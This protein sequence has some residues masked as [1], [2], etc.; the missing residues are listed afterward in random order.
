MTHRRLDGHDVY[1]LINDSPKPWQGRIDFA[2]AGQA[3]QWNPAS[4]KAISLTVDRPFTLSLEPYGAT[5][6]RFSQPPP[7][8]RQPLTRPLPNL[9][10]KPL[11]RFQP[12]T[13]HGEF[14]AAE[15]NRAQAPGRP[16]DT[17]FESRATLTRGKVDTHLFARFHHDSPVSLDGA[18]CLVVDTWIPDGQKTHAEFLMILHEEGGGDFLASTGR[19]LGAPGHE[20]TFVPLSQFHFADWSHDTDGVLDPTR[21]TKDLE[22]TV[23][24]LKLTVPGH[25]VVLLK[26]TRVS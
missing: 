12:I 5:F 4:G 1:F 11:P 18:D 16:D 6:V 10:V 23:G 7:S 24:S 25:G 15:L 9:L 21:I 20:Q 17:R 3:E 19:S 2:A 14:V 13:F 8:P 26:L 22:D